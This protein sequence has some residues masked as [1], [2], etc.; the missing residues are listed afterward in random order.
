MLPT[1]RIVGGTEVPLNRYPYI[2][3]LQKVFHTE[4]AGGESLV[5]I[6]QKCAGT[7]IAE[8]E[9][10]SVYKY[11]E[12]SM[13]VKITNMNFAHKFSRIFTISLSRR[14]YPDGSPLRG[15]RRPS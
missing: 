11:K 14:H 4:V 5:F 10:I 9:H 13:R 7:L 8:G 1:A 15:L 3:S 2:V 12:L 6:A